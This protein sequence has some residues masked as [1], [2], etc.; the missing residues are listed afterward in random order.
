MKTNAIALF[1][2]KEIRRIWHD[3]RWFFCIIDVIAA[4]TNSVDP[5][6]Y[7]KDMR[8]RDLFL[9]DGWGQIATPL[10][11]PTR[12][13]KQKVNC[14][15]TEG[16]L[17]IIQSIPSPKAEPFKRWL[18]KIGYERIQEIDDPEVASKKGG[19]IAG[20]ARKKLEVETG[21]R[22]VSKENYLSEEKGKLQG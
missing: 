12:G 17:R 1:Q 9:S 14:A 8:R 18:A 22:I 5:A 20:D 6:G 10:S 15:D 3:E 11:V 7:I 21:K 4:L 19:K 13:G 16:I 2:Q